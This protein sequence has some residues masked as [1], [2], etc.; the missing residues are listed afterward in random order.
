MRLAG[1]IAIV[2]G[3]NSGIGQAIAE[4]YA[5]EGADIAVLYRHDREGAART[6]REAAAAGRRHIA[7]QGDVG[8]EADVA[9]FFRAVEERLGPPDIL[10]NNAGVMQDGPEVADTPLELFERIIGTNLRGPFLCCR[11]FMR[12]RRALGGG[13]RIIN[14]TS[15]HEAIPSPRAAVYGASKGGLLTFTRSLCLEAAPLRINVNA[16]APGHIVT[17]MTTYRTKDPEQYAREMANI[18]WN[19]PGQPPE[20]AALAVYLA[21]DEADYVTG[22][23]FTIDGGLT[24]NWGQGA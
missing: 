11:E 19:R 1:R 22:Q 17:A 14:V 3:G 12:R 7:I 16:I 13:G 18:P 15:V 8:A 2:T 24:M 9:A 21:S 6:E 23:S 20:V 4:A 5:R 10:V